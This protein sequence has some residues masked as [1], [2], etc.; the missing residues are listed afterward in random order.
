[1]RR[2]VKESLTEGT[3]AKSGDLHGLDGII[4]MRQEPSSEHI[5]EHIQ[6]GMTS[7]PGGDLPSDHPILM[8][9]RRYIYF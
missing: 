3:V 6:A 5:V 7:D 4:P 9:A 8:P 2:M 1:M